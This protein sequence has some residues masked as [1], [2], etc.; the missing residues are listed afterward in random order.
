[1]SYIVITKVIAGYG[2]DIEHFDTLAEARKYATDGDN[3]Y[4]HLEKKGDT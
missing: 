4:K 2:G 1:M 3:I